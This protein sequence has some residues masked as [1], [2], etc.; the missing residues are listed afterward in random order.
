MGGQRRPFT[1]E[2]GPQVG[3]K[4]QWEYQLMRKIRWCSRR[5]RKGAEVR[6]SKVDF[7]KKK[8][9][10]WP[11]QG[12]IYMNTERKCCKGRLEPCWMPAI[13]AGLSTR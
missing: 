5:E 6:V 12:S 2:R 1:E 9:I 10:L 11:E 3:L 8:R 7:G 13:E 4:G